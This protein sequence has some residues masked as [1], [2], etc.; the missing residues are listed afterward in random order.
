MKKQTPALAGLSEHFF[1]KR[2][3]DIGS[4]NLETAEDLK[5]SSPSPFNI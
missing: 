1:A 5:F 3:T 4:A 2:R